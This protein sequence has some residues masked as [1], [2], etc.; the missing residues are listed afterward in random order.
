[1]ILEFPKQTSSW[2]KKINPIDSDF[3]RKIDNLSFDQL[4]EWL[5][6]SRRFSGS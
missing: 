1:M 4:L 5:R 6:Y 3:E 2:I